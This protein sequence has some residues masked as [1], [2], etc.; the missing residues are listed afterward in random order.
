MD[1]FVNKV[2]KSFRGRKFNNEPMSLAEATYWID[3]YNA[4][5]EV[6]NRHETSRDLPLNPE[7]PKASSVAIFNCN[8]VL[9]FVPRNERRTGFIRLAKWQPYHKGFLNCC[10]NRADPANI[11][12]AAWRHSPDL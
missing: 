12:W 10:R 1:A 9:A 2:P 7:W 11:I 6:W 4:W 3:S 8:S 5:V